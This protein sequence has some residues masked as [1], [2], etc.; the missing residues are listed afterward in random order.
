MRIFLKHGIPFKTFSE[1]TKRVYIDVAAKDFTLAYKKQSTSRIA[2]LTGITRKEIQKLKEQKSQDHDEMVEKHHRAAKV[3]SGWLRNPEFSDSEGKIMDLPIEGKNAS[4]QSLV[5]KFS[6]DLPYRAVLDELVRVGTA[7]VIKDKKVRLKTKGYIPS[8]GTEEKVEMMG[9]DVSDLI[10]TFEHN[11][12]SK[13]EDSR[14]QLKVCYDNLPE[15]IIP[16]LQQLAKDK[17]FNFLQD[18]DHWLSS[19][20]RNINPSVKG[21]GRKR[22][23]IG[24]YYFE[25]DL[26]EEEDLA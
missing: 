10:S 11:I 14:L 19:Y 21:K 2:V 7:D 8:N 5:K 16:K 17:G 9:A 20:D 4:F 3:I 25:E 6:G 24:I 23:G 15:D 13:T 1:L 12:G 22:A 26:D 18:F